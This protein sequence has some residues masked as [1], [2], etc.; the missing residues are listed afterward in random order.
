MSIKRLVVVFILFEILLGTTLFYDMDAKI[1]NYKDDFK[2]VH[3][4][5]LN[6]TDIL[7]DKLVAD[8]KLDKVLGNR[9]VLVII[10]D[11]KDLSIEE[12]RALLGS[13]NLTFGYHFGENEVTY[14]TKLGAK[15]ITYEELLNTTD[16]IYGSNIHT[17]LKAINFNDYV[18]NSFWSY[19]S[20]IFKNVIL[21]I[22]LSIVELFIL[23]KFRK[24]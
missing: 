24:K 8:Y 20:V 3:E 1:E 13:K 16:N 2:S 18:F 6:T 19:L 4:S 12:F 22:C 15:S 17:V 9:E 21:F 11:N 10:D 23:F 5:I 14:R 7:N